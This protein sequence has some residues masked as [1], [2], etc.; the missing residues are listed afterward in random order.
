MASSKAPDRLNQLRAVCHDAEELYG[1]AADRV[2]GSDLRPLLR[3]A[4][5]LHREIGDALQPYV[6][7]AGGSFT[8]AGTL[9]GKLRQLRG[10]LRATFAADAEAA[11]LPELQDAE[12]AVVQAFE[13][14]LAGPIDPAAR[15][16][17]TRQPRDSQSDAGPD[18]RPRGA[19]RA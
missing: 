2:D 15:M 18:R 13:G 8:A 5:G 14:A 3:A 4:A 16:L 9:T 19:R 6:S 10:G 12:E 11:L 1:Y 7:G 17:V